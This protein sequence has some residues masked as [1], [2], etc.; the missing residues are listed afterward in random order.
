M[1]RDHRP[2][3]LKKV[4]LRWQRFYV[5]RY[6]RPQFAA[7][8]AHATFFKPWHV[9][10]FGGPVEM[11]ACPNVIANPD[12][13]VRFAVWSSQDG[14]GRISIGDY[15]LICPGVR[16]SSAAS[17]DIGDGTM[18]ASGVYITDSD[19]H[20][21]YDRISMG[22]AKP[23][24]V[25]ANV[26][27]GDQAI[28]CKGVTIGDNSI[29]GAGSVV[30]RD[31]PANVVAAGNPARVVKKLDPKTRFKTRADWFAKPEQLKSEIDGL[32]R[33]MLKKNRLHFWLRHLIW[34][35]RGD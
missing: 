15:C 33:T 2:Y 4:Y 34:P 22:P 6:L 7:L 29:I 16:I 17:I 31:I 27:L 20:G 3:W 21:I 28:V 23:V 1:L 25:G 8:G 32:D 18:L 26:W 19:W 11:G 35:R 13:K 14:K 30:T 24:V 10:I 12:K 5:E 9:E